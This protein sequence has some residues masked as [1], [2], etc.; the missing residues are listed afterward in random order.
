[1]AILASA[2]IFK[3]QL[4]FCTLSHVLENH[5]AEGKPQTY[6][7]ILQTIGNNILSV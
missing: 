1:M 4:L 7:H 3:C 2:G 5:I 6:T